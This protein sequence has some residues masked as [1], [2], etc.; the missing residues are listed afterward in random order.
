MTPLTPFS[1]GCK[2]SVYRGF[3]PLHP[4]TGKFLYSKQ[5]SPHKVQE[6]LYR[7]ELPLGEDWRGSLLKSS[8]ARLTG[9]QTLCEHCEHVLF[10]VTVD[11]STG[12]QT[13]CEHC[14]HKPSKD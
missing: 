11:V 1:R 4:Q 12:G 6:T 14:E 9:G 8:A 13:P 10:L 3:A 5:N 2:A 7:E